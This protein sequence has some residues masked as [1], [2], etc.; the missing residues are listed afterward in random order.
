MR[1]GKIRPS[2]GLISIHES[3]LQGAGT[4]SFICKFVTRVTAIVRG[5]N[6]HDYLVQQYYP[7]SNATL[8]RVIRFSHYSRFSPADY[9]PF[10]YVVQI[11]S[12]FFTSLLTSMATSDKDSTRLCSTEKTR[13]FQRQ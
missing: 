12:C 3:A 5:L 6:L 13:S 10:F 9:T 11:F 2:L 8:V 1:T 4:S 7:V